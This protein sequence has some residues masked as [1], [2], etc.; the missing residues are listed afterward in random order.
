MKSQMHVAADVYLNV[1]GDEPLVRP[2]Q[3]ASLF[4]VMSDSSVG[5]WE[6]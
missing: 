2:E 3:I 5:R 6:L 1:Q 4:D